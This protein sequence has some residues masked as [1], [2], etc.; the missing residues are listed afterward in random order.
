MWAFFVVFGAVFG[1]FCGVLAARMPHKRAI[2]FA[3]SRCEEC[4]KPL[5]LRHL[6]PLVSFFALGGKCAFCGAKIPRA[7]LAY[8]LFGAA[9]ALAVWAF[10]LHFGADLGG[11]FGVDLGGNLGAEFGANFNA[12]LQNFTHFLPANDSNSNLSGNFIPQ[13][14]IIWDKFSQLA[15]AN[16][17]DSANSAAATAPNSNLGEIFSAPAAHLTPAP[18][19]SPIPAPAAPRPALPQIFAHALGLNPAQHALASALAL[20]AFANLLF[21]LALIDIRFCAVP[22]SLLLATLAA[23]LALNPARAALALAFIG[24][25]LVLKMCVSAWISRG[26]QELIEPMGEADLVVFGIIALFCGAA[27]AFAV[28]FLA[29]ILQIILHIIL[30][31]ILQKSEIPFIP[32]LAIALAFAAFA[33]REWLNFWLI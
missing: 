10:Y 26:E 16:A 15:H 2:F 33:P 31:K 23:A 20:V 19:A 18:A 3:R 6:I 13:I 4:E 1:S 22:Q 28:I 5:K 11:S 14:N 9:S 24:G 29:A 27:G 21:A 12:A 17:A 32:A 8:E 7:T 25:A 30:S